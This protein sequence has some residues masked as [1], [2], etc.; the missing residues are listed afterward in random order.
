MNPGRHSAL[1]QLRA[2]RLDTAEETKITALP[3]GTF[4]EIEDRGID[5]IT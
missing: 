4:S 1:E 3:V 5:E 2:S